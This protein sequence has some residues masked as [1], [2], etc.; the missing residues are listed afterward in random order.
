[1]GRLVQRD[2]EL[3]MPPV[4]QEYVAPSAG[5]TDSAMTSP[6]EEHDDHLP[7]PHWIK[8]RIR[9]IELRSLVTDHGGGPV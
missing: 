5:I 7:S 6:I 1:M 4:K 3:I 9:R 2:H 8:Y